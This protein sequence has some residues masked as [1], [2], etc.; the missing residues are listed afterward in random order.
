MGKNNV[1]GVYM[2]KEFKDSY[3]DEIFQFIS[4]NKKLSE[5]FKNCFYSTLNTTVI[6]NEN[7][8]PFV[9]TGDIPA[10]WLRDSSAQVFHYLRFCRENP[11]Y[12]E[13]N[14]ISGI[15]SI[16]T[17]KNFIWHMSL[18]YRALPPRTA[19]K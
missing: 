1:R 7:E 9:I 5:M 3:T 6:Q 18:A 16:H 4:P 8:L 10:M 13:S 11:N 12:V 15:G 17:P 14:G 19:V 2:L